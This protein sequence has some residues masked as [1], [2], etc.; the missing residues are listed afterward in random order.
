MRDKDF[1][2]HERT[3]RSGDEEALTDL[4]ARVFD[5]EMTC[6]EWRWKLRALPSPVENV[7]LAVD[8]DDKPIFQIGGIPRRLQ[9]GDL[10][11]PAMVAVDAMTAVPYRR[12]G[13]LTSV[14]SGLLDRWQDEGVAVVLGLPNEQYGSRTRALGWEPLVELKWRIRPLRPELIVA[15]RIGMPAMAR[16]SWLGALWNRWCD[17]GR[18]PDVAVRELREADRRLDVLEERLSRHRQAGL[19]R[20]SEWIAWRYLHHPDHPYTVLVAEGDDGPL[21]LAAFRM[22]NEGGRRTGWIAEVSAI[23]GT[24]A[25]GSL[26]REATGRLR[27][28]GA[29][30]AAIL[31]TP[32]TPMDRTLLRLGFRFSWGTFV[33][34]MI[35]LQPDL[36][37]AALP[38]SSAWWL[39]GGDFDVV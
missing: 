2:W 15:R 35:T 12:R 24:S 25:A 16:A 31:S 19:V 4:F 11:E 28:A 18:R 22:K 3:Y 5:R 7:A 14:F 23:P 38:N 21:G 1:A 39:S 26:L 27:K 29:E 13:I 8:A 17:R 34:H 33:V 36:D 20:S 9:L 6:E 30:L 10:E 37:I 32:D